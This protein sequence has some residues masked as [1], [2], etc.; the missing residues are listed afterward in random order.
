M[1]M[2]SKEEAEGFT[3]EIGVLKFR[4]ATEIS[5]YYTS[6]IPAVVNETAYYYQF[7]FEVTPESEFTF[8]AYDS[9]SQFLSDFKLVSIALLDNDRIEDIIYKNY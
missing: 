8:F 7:E 6:L 1:A 3:Q 4:Y 5:I 9:A 2:L